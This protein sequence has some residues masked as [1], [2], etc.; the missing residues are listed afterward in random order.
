MHDAFPN[1]NLFSFLFPRTGDD[2]GDV[3]WLTFE[4]IQARMRAN[5]IVG[6]VVR[7]VTWAEKLIELQAIPPPPLPDKGKQ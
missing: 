6:E 1:I 7:V 2:A 3:A 5:A 4:D